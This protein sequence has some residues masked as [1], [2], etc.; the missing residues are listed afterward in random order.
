VPE[1]KAAA[2]VIGVKEIYEIIEVEVCLVP[3]I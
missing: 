3:S 2:R 1:L